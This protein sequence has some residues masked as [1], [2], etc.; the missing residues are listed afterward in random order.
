MCERESKWLSETLVNRKGCFMCPVTNKGLTAE[1][2]SRSVTI[3]TISTF[4]Q[5]LTHNHTNHSQ[6]HTHTQTGGK[7][8]RWNLMLLRYI[9]VFIATVSVNLWMLVPPGTVKRKS[10]KSN[11]YRESCRSNLFYSL[12]FPQA[13]V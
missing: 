12:I 5:Y 9:S 2:K 4:P 3:W 10:C 8:E 1:R 13:K 7:S 11:K 6:T